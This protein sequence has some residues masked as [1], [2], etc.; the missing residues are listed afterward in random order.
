[1]KKFILLV[2]IVVVGLVHEGKSQTNPD[3]TVVVT[4][5]VPFLRIPVDARAA[6]MG[7]IGVATSPDNNSDYHNPAKY[8]F[9]EYTSGFSINYSPW[10][11][12]LVNDIHLISANGYYKI[13]KMQS[14]AASLRMFSMGK[15]DFTDQQGN[16]LGT[17]NPNELCFDVHYSRKVSKKLSFGVSLRYIYSNLA[18]GLPGV[19]QGKP[20]HAAATD[21]SMFYTTPIKMQGDK[22]ARLN[23]GMNISNIGNKM[24]YTSQTVGDY[25]PANFATGIGY[26]MDFDDYNTLNFGLEINKL[27][28]PTPDTAK[29]Q[30]DPSIL[31]Y[32]EKSTISSI[33]S[34]WGDAPGGFA[35]EMKEYIVNFGVEYWYNKLFAVR[36]G[37]FY[38]TGSKGGRNFMTAGLGLKYNAFILNFSYLIPTSS[39]V[40]PLDNTMRFSMVFNFGKAEN[41][42]PTPKETTND[43][44]TIPPVEN[45]NA[46]PLPTEESKPS[47]TEDAAPSPVP[48]EP[49]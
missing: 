48:A 32:K 13:D 42:K 4:S 26:E 2:S 17:G 45:D 36:A 22:K 3:R 5:A 31:D 6:G 28:V 37:Y 46:M 39:T 33:F 1:M 38:E 18:S 27:M 40:N 14:F 20:G 43:E 44:T 25:L 8:A 15:I 21:L 19:T 49:K 35:E 24:I 47:P 23:W 34:S 12:Q 9:M 41:A 10:L 7:D 29:G 16:P 30:G 11:R